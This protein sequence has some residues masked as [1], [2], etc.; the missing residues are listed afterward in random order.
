MNFDKIRLFLLCFSWFAGIVH[1]IFGHTVSNFTNTGVLSLLI[2]FGLT[3]KKLR[4]ESFT[5]IA[6]LLIVIT[7]LLDKFPKF[8]TILSGGRFVLIFSALLPTMIFV[9]SVS[10]KIKRVKVTQK[11]LKELKTENIIPGFQIAS[12]FFG[13]VINT[14]TF[15]ILSASLP[16]DSNKGLRKNVAE[17]CL[18]GMNTSATWSPFFVAFAVG[19]AFIDKTNS[20]IAISFG[21]I[22]GILFNLI[23]IPIFTTGL[24]IKQ[25]KRS[26]F[27]LKPVFPI[28]SL[29]LF[30][31]LTVSIV[32]D[33]TAL[34]AIVLVMPCLIFFY[35]VFNKKNIPEIFL[36]TKLW[37][38]DTSDDIIVISFAMLIG[39][40]ISHSDSIIH[41]NLFFFQSNFHSFFLLVF[42]PL[43]ITILSFIGIHP[44]V[45]STIVLSLLTSE[46]SEIH[47]ALLMQAHLVGWSAGTMS[48]IASL[49]VLTCSNLFQVSSREI[50]YGPNLFTA[51]VFS[52][53][54]G[55]FLGLFNFLSS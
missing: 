23:S 13:S 4:K 25:I 49:S 34:S 17:A 21:F 11:L 1:V 14:G 53:S 55:I 54:A 7:S 37:L 44:I 27:C 39:Y 5:I 36:E 42:T 33:F 8:D 12:H 52:L 50:S 51:I 16:K 9:K 3:I 20:W 41:F 22:F 28:L 40:L 10:S 32:F 45:T 38:I 18:R 46:K 6:I 31:V 15:S 24:N 26:I 48:S 29:I 19:Q 30:S 2:F 47:P 35:L 43:I